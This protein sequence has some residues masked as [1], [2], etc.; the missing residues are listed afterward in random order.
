MQE[1][2]LVGSDTGSDGGTVDIDR[3]GSQCAGLDAAD[4]PVL[5]ET[6]SEPLIMARYL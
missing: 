4:L 1:E 5:L 3:T 6:V 2:V